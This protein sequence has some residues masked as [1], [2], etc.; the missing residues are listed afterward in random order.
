MYRRRIGATVIVY[1]PP[2]QRY[3]FKMLSAPCGQQYED[4]ADNRGQ[5]APHSHA[6]FLL[7]EPVVYLKISGF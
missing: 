5:R 3:L 4:I 1:V 2:C 7:V 6:F